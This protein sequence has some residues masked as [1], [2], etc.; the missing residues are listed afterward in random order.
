MQQDDRPIL[1]KNNTDRGFTATEF[2][3]HIIKVYFKGTHIANFNQGTATADII[4]DFCDSYW[5]GLQRANCFAS[6]VAE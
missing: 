3:D 1:S 5:D 6:Q 4:N 2:G